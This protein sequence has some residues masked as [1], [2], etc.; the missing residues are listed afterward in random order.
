MRSLNKITFINSAAIKYSEIRLDGNIH[1]IGTQ[2]VGKSTVLRAILYF[3]NAESRKLGVPTGPTNKSFAEWYFPYA[4]SYIVYEV[5]KETGAYCVFAFKSQNRVCFRFLDTAYNCGYFIDEQGHALE[6]WD[7]IRGNLDRERKHY[8]RKIISYEEYRDIIY[9][10]SQGQREFQKYALL[11]AKQYKNIPRTIQNV[12]L[13]SKLEANFIKQT[14]ISSMDEEDVHIDLQQ[15]A[16]HLKDFETQLSDIRKFKYPSVMRQAKE[17]ARLFIAINHLEREKADFAKLLASRL[18][19]IEKEKPRL[20]EQRDAEVQKRKIT[21]EEQRKEERLFGSR[22]DRIAEVL[23][24]LKGKLKESKEK[25][26]YYERENIERIINRVES[27][28]DLENEKQ[29]LQSERELLNSAFADINQKYNS[30]IAEKQN[31]LSAFRNSKKE[32]QIEIRR[33]EHKK[34][35]KIDGDYENLIDEIRKHHKA[36]IDHAKEGLELKRQDISFLKNK[37]FELKH[38]KYFEPDIEKLK[39]TIGETENRIGKQNN[40][41]QHYRQQIETLEKQWRLE[42][43]AAQKEKEQQQE[44]LDDKV[45]I[46]RELIDGINHKIESSKDSLYGWLCENHPGWENTIGKTI[47]D[48]VLFLPGLEPRA[49]ESKATNFYGI[50]INLEEIDKRVKTVE[51]YRFDLEN[52]TEELGSC[53]IQQKEINE[54]LEKELEKIQKRNLPKIRD[55][56]KQILTT[57][58]NLE[59]DTQ[60]LKQA[61]VELESL[62][63]KGKEE[64]EKDLGQVDKEIG[65]ATDQELRLNLALAALE[66]Q[67]DRKIA[68]KK[69]EKKKKVDALLAENM[70]LINI[71]EQQVEE[72]AGRSKLQIADLEK[73]KTVALDSKGADT[74]RLAE[75][76]VLLTAAKN[77]LDYIEKHRDLVAGFFKDK[78]ELFDKEK[79]FKNR[80]QLE[81]GKLAELT[82][83]HETQKG[84]LADRMRML[85]GLINGY[86][87]Q[88]EEIQ[89]ELD[90]FANEFSKSEVFSSVETWFTAKEFSRKVET[91]ALALMEQLRDRHYENIQRE[92][93]LRESLDKFLANFSE[94]NIFQFPIKLMGIKECLYFSEELNDFV[95]EN[96]IVLFEKRVN[97]RFADIVQSLGKE[98]SLLISKTGEIQKIVSKI[99]KDFSDKNFVGAVK[100]IELRVEDSKNSV[101]VILKEIK[102]FN[103][104]NAFD[105]GETNLFSSLNK[106]RNNEKSIEL[107]KQLVKEINAAKN[108]NVFLTD[109]FELIFRVEENQND[110]GWVEKLSNVGSDGTDVLVKAMVNIM[111]LNVFKKGA[112]RRFKDF[113]LHCM[114]DEIGRLHPNNV[115]GILKFANDRNI[116]L[117]NG[118]PTENTPLSYKHIY[119]IEKDAANISKIKRIITN[120]S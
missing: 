104:E 34:K 60:K 14:I 57:E 88:I 110:T 4:N 39:S 58:Y 81:E 106:D 94:A 78:A 86:Q 95:E 99:N 13:N 51:D 31:Q 38:K 5:A 68:T 43:Q 2:G 18:D 29:N 17:S 46:I 67:I 7:K 47:D 90:K 98:T 40:N 59:Q 85:V 79:E 53:K 10:N 70:L 108:D 100:K 73:Q 49:V 114:M 9:G 52:K 105:F 91:S 36:E 103:D 28:K 50:H 32:D 116:L 24:Q 3:Y 93:E 71:I 65:Q 8:S 102:K 37:R 6:S 120:F 11:E 72:Y 64:K 111:L 16:H 101:F 62:H 89:K 69:R 19:Q 54:N 48:N 119:K 118:S 82:R 61:T 56:K 113:Q 20:E 27:R 97:E 80:Q 74:K 55:Y 66:T 109:S 83:K 115:K 23:S 107:L 96:K 77:E 63:I 30:L 41:I 75:I 1:F 44:K 87:S 92:R 45:A 26:E 76:D 15:Y 84:K 12:F 112:S 117:I 33:D 35:E 42:K 21:D 22:K 25:K